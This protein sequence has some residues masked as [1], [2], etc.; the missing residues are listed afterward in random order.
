MLFS[1]QDLFWRGG[2]VCLRSDL[3]F[4]FSVPFHLYRDCRWS[5]WI[6]EVLPNSI[7]DVVPQLK[8]DFTST[9]FRLAPDGAICL[10][11]TFDAW[12]SFDVKQE[13]SVEVC[14]VFIDD[15]LGAF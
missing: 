13:L 6:V 15:V 5:S 2:L 10:P 7:F 12:A 4:P 8:F 11:G 14:T 1:L 3:S 9:K